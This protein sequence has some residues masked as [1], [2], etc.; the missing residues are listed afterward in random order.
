MKDTLLHEG[1]LKIPGFLDQNIELEINKE[2]DQYFSDNQYG[3]IVIDHPVKRLIS[4]TRL[5]A[6][7]VL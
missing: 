4:P 2:L 6:N 3:S 7:N 5:N 1:A